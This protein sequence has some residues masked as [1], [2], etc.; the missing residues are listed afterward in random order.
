[1]ELVYDHAVLTV[2]GEKVIAGPN[3][4]AAIRHVGRLSDRSYAESSWHR[5]N[6]NRAPWHLWAHA[7]TVMTLKEDGPL[8]RGPSIT[9][10]S[11][12][13]WHEDV[14]RDAGDM[15]QPPEGPRR[16][17][18]R[19]T[20]G[21]H[22]GNLSRQEA[23]HERLLL[24][25]ENGSHER[26]SP[27]LLSAKSSEASWLLKATGP[28]VYTQEEVS[29]LTLSPQFKTFVSQDGTCFAGKMTNCYHGTTSLPFIPNA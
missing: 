10:A 21:S 22:L 7:T 27:V 12:L 28:T 9:L 18:M 2:E 16:V 15:L 5:R 13:S 11:K 4:L 8:A 1:M 24:L 19:S 25:A 14:P 20:R 6:I 29:K 17:L 3:G 23:R 26:Q